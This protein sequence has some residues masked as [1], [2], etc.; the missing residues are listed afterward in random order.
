MTTVT[1]RGETANTPELSLNEL[2]QVAGGRLDS[3]GHGGDVLPVA[4]LIAAAVP[5]VVGI[6]AGLWRDIFGSK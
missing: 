4:M 1:L 3:G 2:D 6:V 5:V